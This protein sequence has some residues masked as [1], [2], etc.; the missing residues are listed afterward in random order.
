MEAKDLKKEELYIVV[1]HGDGE[2]E[3]TEYATLEEATESAEEYLTD[4]LAVDDKVIIAQKLFIYR[5]KPRVFS[6]IQV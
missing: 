5:A 4:E 6:K 3:Y 2:E 1:F